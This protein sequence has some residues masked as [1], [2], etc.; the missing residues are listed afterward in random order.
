MIKSRV[1]PNNTTMLNIREMVTLTRMRQ[2]GW[3]PWAKFIY[4]HPYTMTR[5]KLVMLT[6]PDNI[7]GI[8]E[9]TGANMG[10]FALNFG[11]KNYN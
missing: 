10:Y 3:I 2:V 8:L 11:P 9:K 1:Q 4:R 6:M 7:W 5:T